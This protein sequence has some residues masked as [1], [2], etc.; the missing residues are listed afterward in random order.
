MNTIIFNNINN[1]VDFLSVCGT[2]AISAHGELFTIGDVVEHEDEEAGIATIER[3]EF[4]TESMD[5][6]AYTDKGWARICFISK[7]NEE[8]I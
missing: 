4:D 2:K 7:I 8:D 3:F 6:R 5:V 1:R